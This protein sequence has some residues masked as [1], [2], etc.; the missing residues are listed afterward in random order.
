[1][2]IEVLSSRVFVDDTG[3]KGARFLTIGFGF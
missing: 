1:M 2:G 3:G